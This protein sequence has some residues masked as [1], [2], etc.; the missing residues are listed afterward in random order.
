MSS[1]KTG[2]ETGHGQIHSGQIFGLL[3]QDGIQLL[4]NLLHKIRH[5]HWR[6]GDFFK[7]KDK[8]KKK[9]TFT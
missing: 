3:D 8:K 9:T 6:G 2:G 4:S 5:V 7:K 1:R